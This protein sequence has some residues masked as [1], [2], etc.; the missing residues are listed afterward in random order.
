MFTRDWLIEG[1]IQTPAWRA[2]DAAVVA[3]ARGAIEARF[4]DLLARHHPNEAK[5][6]LVYPV[7]GALGWAHVSVQQR[8]D[9][10]GRHGVRD[11][12]L[13]PDAAK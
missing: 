2:L 9:S 13:F 8:M 11:A 7:L 4:A 10:R 1:V 6:E 5:T 12:L 3:S